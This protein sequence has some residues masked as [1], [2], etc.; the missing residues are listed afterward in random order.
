MRLPIQLQNEI[1][2]Y[3]ECLPIMRDSDGQQA[4]IYQA[5]LDLRLQ[6]QIPFGKPQAEF[7]AILVSKLIS[8]GNLED[9]R[10]A[11]VAVLEVT[12]NYIGS[13]SV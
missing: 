12:K 10:N 9:G 11:L 8:Y 13:D 1:I 5:G 6:T 3:F 2:E 7:A 4:L